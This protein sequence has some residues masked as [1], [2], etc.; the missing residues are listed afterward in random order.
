M[1]NNLKK[2]NQCSSQ[3]KIW[4]LNSCSHY[5]IYPQKIAKKCRKMPKIAEKFNKFPKNAEK[6]PKIAEK[7]P[8][9]AEKF[10]DLRTF[11]RLFQKSS[12]CITV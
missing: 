7:L 6:L 8:K 2:T 3:Q 10:R 11:I 5:E 9:I 1:F 12:S 4:R